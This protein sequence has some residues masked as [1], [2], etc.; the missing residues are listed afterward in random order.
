MAKAAHEQAF[1]KKTWFITFT[2]RPA[3]RARIMASASSMDRAKAPGKRLVGASGAAVTKYFKRLRKAGFEIRYVC[4]PELHRDG[5]PHWHGLIHD[6]RGD[7]TWA[8]ASSQWRDGY[9]VVKLVKDATAIRYVTKYLSKAN[10]GR[11][12]ASLGYGETQADREA[13]AAVSAW[14]QTESGGFDAT[15]ERERETFLESTLHLDKLV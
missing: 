14:E 10:F 6:L 9:S 13:A 5:F 7:L 8:A 1:A 2:F 15:V 12:R 11:V 4:I 3:E